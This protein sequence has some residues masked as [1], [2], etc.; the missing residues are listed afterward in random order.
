[1][2]KQSPAH[3]VAILFVAARSVYQTMDVECYDVERDATTFKCDRPVVAHPPCGPWGRLRRQCTK[4][5][6]LLGPWAVQ[7]VRLSGGV[8]E[9]PAGSLLWKHCQLPP[10]GPWVDEF[11]GFTI[12]TTLA[13]HG[14]SVLKP[15]WLY[16]VRVD[17]PAAITAKLG[18][19]TVEQLHSGHRQ[20]TPIAMAEWLVSIARSH[21]A[22]RSSP[23]QN[24]VGT[25]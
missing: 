14:G 12:E 15:T 2:V 1:M 17:R 19:R 7:V 21:R 6:S 11:G 18:W 10:P 3:P 4:Q 24:S 25:L 5:S 16:C 9:H 8:L 23:C 13:A 20:L 22:S